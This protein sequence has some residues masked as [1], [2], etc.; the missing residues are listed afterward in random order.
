MNKKH[1]KQTCDC[2]CVLTGG[3]SLCTFHEVRLLLRSWAIFRNRLCAK[4]PVL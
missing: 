4:V 2:V 1:G 3:K